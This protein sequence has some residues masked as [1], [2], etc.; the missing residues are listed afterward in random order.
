VP[1][2]E[3]V[4]TDRMEMFKIDRVDLALPVTLK[5]HSLGQD[6]PRRQLLAE[7]ARD[8]HFR[9]ELPCRNGTRAFERLQGAFQAQATALVIEQTAQGRLKLPQLPTNYVVY[10]DNVLPDE[11]LQL[12]QAASAEDKK[13]AGKKP[14]EGQFDRLVLTRMTPADHKELAT[15]IGVDPT[16]PP[17]APAGP[18]GTDPRQPLSDLTAKQVADALAGQG[19]KPRPE[20]G[21]PAARPAERS[22]LVLAYNPVRPHPGSAEIKRFLEGRKPP[23]PGTL[24]VLLVLR[25]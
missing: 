23:R 3:T 14:L 16:Q 13:I 20:P 12:L 8:Q 4:L 9:L 19:G 22:A 21:K 2:E 25:G 1:K 17:P 24:R 7:L 15:L 6:T 18:L 11:L 5:V 10:L